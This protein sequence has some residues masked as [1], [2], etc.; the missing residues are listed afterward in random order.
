V[1]QNGLV[2]LKVFD[3]LGREVS[4]IIN[5]DFKAGSYTVDYNAS[6]LP[7]G[8]YFYKLTSGDFTETKKMVLVK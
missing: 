4:T 6:V 8:V 5:K 3:V 7:S 1:P 2:V